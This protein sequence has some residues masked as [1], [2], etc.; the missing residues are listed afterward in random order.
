MEERTP[1]VLGTLWGELKTIRLGVL[2]PLRAWLRDR[3]WSLRWVR[4]F[5]FFGFFPLILFA[6]YSGDGIALGKAF[7]LIGGYLA[8]IWALVFRF[9]LLPE[10]VPTKLLAKIC[11]FNWVFCLVLITL[12]HEVPFVE[13]MYKKTESEGFWSRFAGHT[14]GV[15][16]VEE[17]VKA[18]PVFLFLYRK[19]LPY[20]P[21]TY[22]FLGAISG[23]AFGVYEGVGYCQSFALEHFQE[24]SK[25]FATPEAVK[26]I[27]DATHA[28]G[29]LPILDAAGYGRM[30]LFWVL[31][32]FNVPLGHALLTGIVCYFMGLATQHTHAA[33]ALML[34]GLIIAVV[35]HG[36]GNA[37]PVGWSTA[38]D[39]VLLLVFVAYTRS[40]ELIS[41]QVARPGLDGARP[42]DIGPGT[43]PSDPTSSPQV[44]G[45]RVAQVGLPVMASA[46]LPGQ[47]Q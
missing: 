32:L 35:F 17:V 1:G 36:L 33:R 2:F 19:R 30:F 15:G 37:L 38:S 16:L 12:A 28:G 13:A 40:D 6:Y 24:M 47:I 42:D 34:I 4:W 29:V 20:R 44:N 21:L 39:A 18:L 31:R 25:V 7:W 46:C 9:C 11:L 5:I 23:L 41:R 26:L 8:L 45:A 22:A 3:P 43:V 27:N 14:I 10:S